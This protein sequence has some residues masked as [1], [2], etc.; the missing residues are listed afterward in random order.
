MTYQIFRIPHELHK[1]PGKTESYI[2]YS[3]V[4]DVAQGELVIFKAF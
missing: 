3:N 2:S 1:A 4:F